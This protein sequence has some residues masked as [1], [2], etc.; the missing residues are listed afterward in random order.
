MRPV[1]FR[2][3]MLYP[4]D[5]LILIQ[6][7]KSKIVTLWRTIIKYDINNPSVF[8]IFIERDIMELAEL[9]SAVTQLQ[10]RSEAIREWL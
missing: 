7:L 5:F 3:M 6:N 2:R 4:A 9:K 1:F 10:A 8:T